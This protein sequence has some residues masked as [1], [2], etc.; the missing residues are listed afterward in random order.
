MAEWRSE[1]LLTGSGHVEGEQRV[2]VGRVQ[3]G[4]A[5]ARAHHGAQLVAHVLRRA[6]RRARARARA[7]ASIGTVSGRRA[8]TSTSF[9]RIALS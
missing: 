4:A 2:E 9:P 5:D 7:Y 8:P 1:E 6:A 3:V